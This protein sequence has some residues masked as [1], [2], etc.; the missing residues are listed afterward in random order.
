MP[1]RVVP[2]TDLQIRNA[3]SRSAAYK[4]NYKNGRSAHAVSDHEE[5][6]LQIQEGARMTLLPQAQADRVEQLICL[7]TKRRADAV[8]T[9]AIRQF[10]EHM[11]CSGGIAGAGRHLGCAL[12]R[13]PPVVQRFRDAVHVLLLQELPNEQAQGGSDTAVVDR[14]AAIAGGCC[15]ELGRCR[16]HQQTV[17]MEGGQRRLRRGREQIDGLGYAVRKRAGSR[18]AVNP[19][20]AGIIRSFGDA[21]PS[22]EFEAHL[23]C[24][25]LVVV[26]DCLL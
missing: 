9:A 8:G 23:L 4:L 7:A 25:H 26:C 20:A 19:K 14:H 10:L 5:G 17:L 1:K 12:R 18:L 22:E 2:L 3:K 21:A 16:V 11:A 24:V 15:V 6:T 13:S